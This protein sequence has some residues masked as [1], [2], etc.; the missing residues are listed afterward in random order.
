MLNEKI[1]DARAAGDNEAKYAMMRTK[2]EIEKT[3]KKIKYGIEAG[4]K[5]GIVTSDYMNYGEK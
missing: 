2:A 1:E 5:S 4:T 3:I